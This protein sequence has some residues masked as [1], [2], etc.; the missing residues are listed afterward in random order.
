[1][2]RMTSDSKTLRKHVFINVVGFFILAVALASLCQA[3]TRTESG[4]T[5]LGMKQGSPSGSYPLSGFETVSPYSGGLSF[6]LPLLQIGGR[7]SASF[8]V[9]LKRETK[10]AVLKSGIAG[11][12]NHIGYM[13]TLNGWAV[14]NPGYGPGH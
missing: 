12:L 11:P 9:V 2:I 5:P 4:Q 14:V 6:I 8:N 7:G 3:Q 1:M 10:W 13:P